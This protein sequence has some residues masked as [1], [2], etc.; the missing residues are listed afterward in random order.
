MIV[1]HGEARMRA[2][3]VNF[4]VGLRRRRSKEPCTSFGYLVP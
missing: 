2:A 3:P 1:K 4:G